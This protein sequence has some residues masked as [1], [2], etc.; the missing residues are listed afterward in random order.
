MN[1]YIST[2]VYEL[3]QF[4][5]KGSLVLVYHLRLTSPVTGCLVY[6]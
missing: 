3:F 5:A 2:F 6:I 4:S 1:E